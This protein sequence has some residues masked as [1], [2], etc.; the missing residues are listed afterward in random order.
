M[1]V[2]MPAALVL[3]QAPAFFAQVQPV[4]DPLV[5][6]K[7]RPQPR[8]QSSGE[9]EAFRGQIKSTPEDSGNGQAVERT[10]QDLVRMAGVPVMIEMKL[11]N[12]VSHPVITG[13]PVK[14]ETM[15]KILQ[16]TPQGEADPEE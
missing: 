15:Q 14:E 9:K 2:K 3:Q 13:S 16:Q 10:N 1:V 4:M 11:V 8:Q 5:V 12:D 6:E 7:S